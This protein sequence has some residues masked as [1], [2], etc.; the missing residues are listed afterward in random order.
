MKILSHPTYII[1]ILGTIGSSIV[2]ATVFNRTFF[3]WSFDPTQSWMIIASFAALISLLITLFFSGMSKYRQGKG[4]L[5]FLLLLP[6]LVVYVGFDGATSNE[7]IENTRSK[8]MQG[9][10]SKIKIDSTEYSVA[11]NEKL[12]WIEKQDAG[13]GL[14][15]TQI[16]RCEQS[17]QSAK[18]A[19]NKSMERQRESIMLGVDADTGSNELTK[20]LGYLVAL[21][22]AAF[23]L[24]GFAYK[25]SVQYYI[26]EEDKYQIVLSDMVDAI[27]TGKELPY[28]YD[29]WQKVG[30]K[31]RSAFY[32][33][34]QDK[35]NET[36]E[37]PFEMGL[38]RNE[39]G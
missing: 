37:K 28:S 38:K 6:V 10:L 39:M 15:P 12:Y 21:F 19:M 5:N 18:D 26:P 9:I 8:R 17:M 29:S 20:Y 23:G 31:N 11:I 1:I 7:V 2:N 35:L 13:D 30:A 4:D 27:R 33:D 36:N 25:E 22:P 34:V 16:R 32:R 14:Y 3:R 24:A